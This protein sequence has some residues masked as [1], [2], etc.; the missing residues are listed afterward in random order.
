MLRVSEQHVQTYG[1]DYIRE[2][3]HMVL[4]NSFRVRMKSEGP[5]Q[6]AGLLPWTSQQVEM[7]ISSERREK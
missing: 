6:M 5:F 2:N 4:V 3:G 1:S 7:I